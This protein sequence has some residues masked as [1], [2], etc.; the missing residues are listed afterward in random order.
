MVVGSSHYSVIF[1]LRN[2]RE[3]SAVVKSSHSYQGLDR[4]W[5]KLLACCVQAC[6]YHFILIN[7][8]LILSMSHKRLSLCFLNIKAM[9]NNG[10]IY[11]KDGC[12]VIESY[13]L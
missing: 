10:D 11:R 8:I 9:R 5:W 6:I 4:L 3:M 12:S 2:I 1:M 13:S 7:F